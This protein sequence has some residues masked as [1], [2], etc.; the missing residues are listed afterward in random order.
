MQ[1]DETKWLALMSDGN[2]YFADRSHHKTGASALHFNNDSYGDLALVLGMNSLERERWCTECQWADISTPR[3][4]KDCNSCQLRAL[5]SRSMMIAA[6][7]KP[8]QPLHRC[9]VSCAVFM[10]QCPNA[11]ASTMEDV[12]TTFC[13]ARSRTCSYLAGWL[14]L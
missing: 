8:F 3:D 13:L 2:N 11:R 7:T 12:R 1:R 10:E 5:F 9:V 4:R 14:C 6:P